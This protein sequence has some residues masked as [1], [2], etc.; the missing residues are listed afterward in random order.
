MDILTTFFNGWIVNSTVT[1]G[2]GIRVVY[3]NLFL[4]TAAA[5]GADTYRFFAK[6][7]RFELVKELE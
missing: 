5:G 7:G 6:R 3:G 2:L 1:A 4:V